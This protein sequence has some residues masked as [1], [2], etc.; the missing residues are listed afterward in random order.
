MEP[1]HENSEEISRYL[2]SLNF[3][4]Y[5]LSLHAVMQPGNK[6][7]LFRMSNAFIGIWYIVFYYY[8]L[9]VQ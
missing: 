1:I 4:L 9:K 5:I 6:Y 7:I 2:L 8:D 3:Q